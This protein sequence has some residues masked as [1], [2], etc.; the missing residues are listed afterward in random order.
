[1]A[2]IFCY[3]SKKIPWTVTWVEKPSSDGV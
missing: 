2:K 1:M 3:P